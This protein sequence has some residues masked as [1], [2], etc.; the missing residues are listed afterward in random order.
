MPR[1]QCPFCYHQWSRPEKIRVHLLDYHREVLSDEFL[2]GIHAARGQ[3][4]VA[5]LDDY[6]VRV[7]LQ[8]VLSI[9]LFTSEN[10]GYVVQL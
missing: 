10:A 7:L 3:A 1:R 5:Y 9:P 2:Q 8:N 4:L 6:Q